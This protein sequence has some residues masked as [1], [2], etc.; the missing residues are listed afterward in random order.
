MGWTC[1]EKPSNVKE[2]LDEMHTSNNPNVSMRVLKSGLK[3]FKEYYAAVEIIYLETNESKVI[4]CVVICEFYND[5]GTPMISYKEMT[6]SCGPR[7]NNC[8]ESILKLL[9]DTD[10]DYA[11]NWRTECWNKINMRKAVSAQ[12]KHGKKVKFEPP[13]SFTDGTKHSELYV[14]KGQRK[15]RFASYPTTDVGTSVWDMP[16]YRINKNLL[17]SRLVLE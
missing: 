11:S 1:T 13:I 4:C 5:C 7:V 10:S 15:V 12:I 17:I 8:P 14:W 2:Y 6:D 16:S 9:T 3:N